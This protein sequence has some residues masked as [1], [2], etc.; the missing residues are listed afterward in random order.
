MDKHMIK[1]IQEHIAI[2]DHIKAIAS[3]CIY[4][5]N[6]GPTFLLVPESDV[7]KVND[8]CHAEY[9]HDLAENAKSGDKIEQTYTGSAAN[10]LREWVN[11]LPSTLYYD[12]VAEYISESEPT[13]EEIDGEWYEP[14]SYYVIETC[15]IIEAL[16]GKTF[17]REFS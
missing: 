14:E 7:T 8:D 10:A 5:L 15:D 1:A 3:A 2:P 11:D 4:D 17:A 12:A 6:Y 16:F 13:G 9:Y